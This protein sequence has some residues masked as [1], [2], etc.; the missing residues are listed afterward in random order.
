MMPRHPKPIVIIALLVLAVALGWQLGATN[1]RE[2][3]SELQKE[4]TL[5]YAGSSGSGTT[6]QKRPEELNFA[7]V[8]GV[9]R[10][11]QSHYIEPQE[12]DTQTML[13]GA[14]HGF[15]NAIEDPYTT[16]MNPKENDDFQD[17]LQGKLE[18]IGAELTMREGRIVIVAPLNGSPASAAGLLPE[19][20]IMAVDGEAIDGLSLTD[21]VM[22]I[23]GPKGTTVVLTIERNITE[24]LDVSITRDVITV[25]STEIEVKE[26]GSGSLG[27]IA[28]NQFG[29]NTAREVEEGVRSVLEQEVEAIIIDV[30]YNGGGYLDRAVEMTSLFLQQG[31][32]VS[33]KRRDRDPEHHYVNGRPLDTEIP[34]VVLINEGSASASEILA[35]A[36]QDHDRATLVGKKSF[37]KGT[38]QEVF[39]LPGGSSLRVT[40]ARWFTPNG[41]DLGKEGV[42]PDIEVDRT[43]EQLQAGEDPQLDAAIEWL[44]DDE[45]INET[46][47]E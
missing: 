44:L 8:Q 14:A 22:R 43:L 21:V 24:T 12:M 46:A 4:L 3:L 7:L 18:G 45:V 31:K 27:Y 10:L 30:R 47:E 33:V 39:D 5:L 19:D 6:V 41:T 23:R 17:S 40:T 38:I 15:V 35:G 25:P 32:V 26:T 16:F 9:W 20:V 13:Y 29:A 28:L 1:E 11:L 36:L 42:S 37:G 34:L 2:R